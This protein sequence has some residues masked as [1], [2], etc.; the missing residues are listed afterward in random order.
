MK[1]MVV[2]KESS[3]MTLEDILRTDSSRRGVS[4]ESPGKRSEEG[5]DRLRTREEE[6]AME[7]KAE[8]VSS[9]EVIEFE[10]EEAAAIEKEQSPK[11]VK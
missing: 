9:K 1:D 2:G 3:R 5:R 11:K 10:D 8:S 6:D 4:E 7:E